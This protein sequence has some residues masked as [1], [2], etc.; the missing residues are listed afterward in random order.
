[1]RKFS[2]EHIKLWRSWIRLANQQLIILQH[3][4]IGVLTVK[5]QRSLQIRRYAPSGSLV[6]VGEACPAME[7]FPLLLWLP[8]LLAATAL[9][10]ANAKPHK[11][12]V[13]KAQAPLRVRK[14]LS[15]AVPRI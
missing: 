13:R 3:P 12:T 15:F 7:N 6:A 14:R 9:D 2:I 5:L 1:M 10:M 4:W 11:S 8:V